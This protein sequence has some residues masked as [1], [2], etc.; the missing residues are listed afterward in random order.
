MKAAAEKQRL[1]GRTERA[2]DMERIANSCLD[3][4][5]YSELK[6]LRQL[7]GKFATQLQ[8]AVVSK[9]SPLSMPTNS[10]HLVGVAL[11]GYMS[12]AAGAEMGTV[13]S[14]GRTF[15]QT[16]GSGKSLVRGIPATDQERLFAPHLLVLSL[17]FKHARYLGDHLW[18]CVGDRSGKSRFR[19]F[20][21]VA[22]GR[23]KSLPS[24]SFRIPVLSNTKP[25]TIRSAKVK[26][27]EGGRFHSDL[28]WID[29]QKARRSSNHRHM[30]P[31]THRIPPPTRS[32]TPRELLP[33]VGRLGSRQRKAHRAGAG[34]R[35][36]SRPEQ[37]CRL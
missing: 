25:V 37:I 29:S 23:S 27:N 14:D 26:G 8:I 1:E 5:D 32:A 6:A 18:W 35:R 20:P 12:L 13:K 34:A 21:I 16:T 33:P 9:L 11:G 3:R 17:C 4:Q 22:G 15:A 30:A 36:E 24:K 31:S 28:G 2:R 7:D 19:A 10:L